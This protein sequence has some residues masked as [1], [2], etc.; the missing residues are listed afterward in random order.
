M[1]Y[2]LLAVLAVFASAV[3]A[4]LLGRAALRGLRRFVRNL[5]PH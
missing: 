4:W 1:T 2:P 3:A 5:W